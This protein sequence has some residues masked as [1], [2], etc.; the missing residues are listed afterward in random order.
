[1]DDFE[2]DRT[3]DAVNKR[4]DAGIETCYLL[5]DPNLGV[6]SSSVVKELYAHKADTALFMPQGIDL[7]KYL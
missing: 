3:I 6:I 4:L 7:T 2:S 5:T 1:M